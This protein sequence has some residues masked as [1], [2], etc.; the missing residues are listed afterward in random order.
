MNCSIPSIVRETVFGRN[1]HD[2]EKQSFSR[3]N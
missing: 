1:L 2:C 3:V